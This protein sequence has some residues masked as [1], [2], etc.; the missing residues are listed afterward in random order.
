MVR[1]LEWPERTKP[2]PNQRHEQSDKTG[3]MEKGKYKRITTQSVKFIV[4]FP[5]RS[6]YCFPQT[7]FLKV[8]IAL[9]SFHS[10][11]DSFFRT[12]DISMDQLI[13]KT[14]WKATNQSIILTEL[15]VEGGLFENGILKQCS[16]NSENINNA[17]NC[18]LNWID[19]VKFTLTCVNY[20]CIL[21]QY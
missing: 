4:S 2:I 8:I 7:R 21:F 1:F 13:L 12:V 5:S 14:S 16:A 6:I 9:Y 11:I 20:Y 18:Y 10:V 3:K 17:P 15:L 19:K